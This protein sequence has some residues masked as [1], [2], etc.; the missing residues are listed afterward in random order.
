MTKERMKVFRKI[1]HIFAENLLGGWDLG[2][3]CTHQYIH[4]YID[5]ISTSYLVF[6]GYIIFIFF[7]TKENHLLSYYNQ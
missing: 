2:K 5:W 1:L 7:K 3:E 6:L 4:Y